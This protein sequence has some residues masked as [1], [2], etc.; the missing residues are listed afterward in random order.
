MVHDVSDELTFC[1]GG[2]KHGKILQRQKGSEDG[3]KP[4]TKWTEFSD[5]F[6]GDVHDSCERSRPDRDLI[7]FVGMV[8]G[9]STGEAE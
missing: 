2:G 1:R 5:R 7:G 4:G 6:T 9:V 8:G 3:G